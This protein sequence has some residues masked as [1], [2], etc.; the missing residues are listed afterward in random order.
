M[1]NQS[2]FL[3]RATAKFGSKFEFIN[4]QDKIGE[5]AYIYV[6]CPEH[7]LFSIRAD[8]FF[9]SNTGCPKCSNRAKHITKEEFLA[10]L[11]SIF[12]NY[13]V[14]NENFVLE[15]CS[16][17]IELICDKGHIFKQD[18]V[19]LHRAKQGCPIC[20]K[21]KSLQI[22]R[23]K[24][25][26]LFNEHKSK[27][28]DFLEP[29]VSC[30]TVTKARCKKC[31]AIFQRRTDYF[32]NDRK[33]NICE[34]KSFKEEMI[35]KFQEKYGDEYDYELP[36]HIKSYNTKKIKITHKYCGTIFSV[37]PGEHLSRNR[38]CP[39]C[40]RKYSLG[41]FTI[42]QILEKHKIAFTYQKTF[43]DFKTEK[44]Y[45]YRYDFF[46][47]NV[48]ILIEYDGRQHF[49]PVDFSGC[50][51]KTEVLKEFELSKKHDFLKNKYAKDHN[52]FLLRISY[53]DFSNLENIIM[54]T[55][56]T[57]GCARQKHVRR[58]RIR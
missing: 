28:F 46:I 13:R 48:N 36:N 30:Q 29:F 51:D 37:T 20:S 26:K 3:E 52:I 9:R 11:H 10:E 5:E 57:I 19:H 35:K 16:E 6:K 22:F 32:F 1:M 53:R 58:S 49:E 39:K 23:E 17:K 21:E 40:F 43:D 33:C 8:S 18:W 15:S 12:P 56:E 55:F 2:E 31:G 54:K 27:Y 50:A 47:P 41:E 4:L 24:N 38:I 25:L 7:G 44:G 45:P 34:E 14:K 42:K